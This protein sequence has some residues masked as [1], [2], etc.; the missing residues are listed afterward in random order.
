MKPLDRAVSGENV[1]DLTL[2]KQ[3]VLESCIS[4][5]IWGLEL[6]MMKVRQWTAI[7]LVNWKLTLN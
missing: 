6:V 2:L 1:G 7:P 4:R 3:L 5:G